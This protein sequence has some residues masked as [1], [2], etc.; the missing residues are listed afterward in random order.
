MDF[1]PRYQSPLGYRTG[2]NGIDSYGVN[3]KNFS[4]RDELEYQLAR[5]EREQRLMDGYNA[6]GINKNYPQFGTDFWGNPENNYGFGQSN[7]AQNIAQNQLKHTSGTPTTTTLGLHQ[8]RYSGSGQPAKPVYTNPDP[9]RSSA[10]DI[11]WEG[12]KGFGDGI[13]TSSLALFNA[14]TN[15]VFDLLSYLYMDDYYGKRQDE[16]QTLA[17]STGL[18]DVN[19]LV[20]FAINAGGQLEAINGIYNVSLKKALPIIKRKLAPLIKIFISKQN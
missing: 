17:E 8:D 9:Q 3:H 15:D 18:G 7:V 4:L 12:L 13:E 20:N 11:L 1:E 2:N 14:A 19:K 10:A 6:R 16:M 5:H